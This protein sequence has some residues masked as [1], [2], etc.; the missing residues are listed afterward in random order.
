[1]G[2]NF[3]A[4]TG[5]GS[6]GVLHTFRVYNV[7]S[8]GMEL[9]PGKIQVAA[10]DLILYQKGKEPIK[11][12]LRCLRRYGFD[13]ELFS[14]ESGRRC[15][16]GPGIYAFK[17]RTAED[18][19]DMVQE[20]IQRAG[21]E[22]H[23]RA[24]SGGTGSSGGG[25][26][27]GI[28]TH[29]S[30]PNSRPASLVEPPEQY[31]FMPSSSPGSSRQLRF[32]SSSSQSHLYINGTVNTDNGNQYVNTGIGQRSPSGAFMLD[33]SAPLIAFMNQPGQRGGPGGRAQVNYAVLDLPSSMENLLDEEG[34][35]A[36]HNFPRPSESANRLSMPAD[37]SAALGPDDGLLGAGD[38]DVFLADPDGSGTCPTY[39]NVNVDEPSPPLTRDAEAASGVSNG[40]GT[41]SGGGGGLVVNRTAGSMPNYANLTMHGSNGGPRFPSRQQQQQ[42]PPAVNYI[43]LDLNQVPSD[44]AGPGG[45]GSNMSPT[46]PTSM[47]S[48]P[49]S[50]GYA[51]IDFNK[52]EA[53]NSTRGGTDGEDEPGARKTRHNSTIGM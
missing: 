38:S 28:F 30:R 29:T 46:S 25:G 4:A 47:V 23:M 18:L 3:S 39:I 50:P 37:L 34:Q 7:D 14:F 13:A 19:F 20:S 45:G 16:T 10:S 17:C 12:P 11:W 53:L 2:C 42:K 6:E 40:G 44:S 8:H 21:Q 41:N 33:E 49:E 24:S 1:M 32:A 9:N 22:D 51:T 43:Q 26:S 31:G 36:V 27:H 35:G 52:T 5:D 48:V 15:P